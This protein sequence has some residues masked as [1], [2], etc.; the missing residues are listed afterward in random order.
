MNFDTPLL[1]LAAMIITSPALCSSDR[2][3]RHLR[4][5]TLKLGK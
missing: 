5:P 4:T 3:L 2:A 1:L